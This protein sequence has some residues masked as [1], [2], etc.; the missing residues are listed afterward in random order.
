MR[1]RD[2]QPIYAETYRRRVRTRKVI[3]GVFLL[4]VLL[5]TAFSVWRW[6]AK[7]ELKRYPIR[8]VSINQDNGYIDF[9]SLK[10]NG[11]KFVYLKAT[12]GATYTDDSFL[13][14]FQRSQGSQLPVGVYH[15]F[16]FSSSPKAQ[17]K[18]F[19]RQVKTNTGSLPI[20]ISIQYY[21]GYNDDS[22]HWKSTRKNVRTL[23]SDIRHYYQR[24][25]VISTSQEIIQ[26]L[27]IEATNAHQ[28]WTTDGQLGKPNGDATFIQVTQKQDFRL[29]RQVVFLPMSVFNGDARQWARYLGS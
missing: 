2:V 6:H 5:I 7:Q 23:M 18:N 24:P 21:G 4:I 15:Y 11:V 19:V 1:R 3:F 27:K 22:V 12:Q 28:F 26:R 16:S 14:N 8:G 25:V 9:E 20:C 13:S 29:D 10:N 17:F